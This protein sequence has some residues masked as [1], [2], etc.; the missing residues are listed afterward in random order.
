MKKITTRAVSVL[1]L[2][3][4]VI[5]GLTIYVLRYLDDGRSWALAFSRVNAGSY[6]SILD[7]NG[8]KLAYFDGS[9]SEYA[10]DSFTRIANYHVTGD[11]GGRSG[12]GVLNTFW[13]NMQ[14]FSLVTGT[15]RS[16]ASV[17]NLT[18]DAELNR[19]AYSAIDGRKAAVLVC[20]Y[21]NG[22]VLAMVST[23]AIDPADPDAVPADGAYINRCLS[24]AFTPARSSS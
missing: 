7:R 11:Y 12:S 5:V 9:T 24:S 16:K 13:G 8:V 18:V 22:D 15:T 3:A 23:P 17:L 4:A 10:D 21:T 1:L 20:D 6:G 14:G 19:V 2:A